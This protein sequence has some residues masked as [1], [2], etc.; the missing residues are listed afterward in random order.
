MEFNLAEHSH[1]KN[2]AVGKCWKMSKFDSR[3]I[4]VNLIKFVLKVSKIDVMWINL[5]NDWEE[6]KDTERNWSRKKKWQAFSNC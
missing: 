6:V 4:Y 1:G 2:K 5:N 3:V